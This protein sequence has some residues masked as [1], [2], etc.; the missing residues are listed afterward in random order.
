MHGHATA[1]G[2]EWQSSDEGGLVARRRSRATALV[3]LG[4]LLGAPFVVALL[5]ASPA[6]LAYEYVEP[7]DG[8]TVAEPSRANAAS[9]VGPTGEI[10]QPGLET[11]A[12]EKLRQLDENPTPGDI[13]TAFGDQLQGDDTTTSGTEIESSSAAN[14]AETDTP[15][16][17][18]QNGSYSSTARLLAANTVGTTQDAAKV[19][20]VA[21]DQDD[22]DTDDDDMSTGATAVVQSPGTTAHG[23]DTAL[24]VENLG[25]APSVEAAPSVQRHDAGVIDAQL[26]AV[27][28]HEQKDLVASAPVV[29]GGNAASSLAKLGTVIATPQPR[30]KIRVTFLTKPEAAPDGVRW[31]D[32]DSGYPTEIALGNHIDVYVG[33]RIRIDQIF[34]S[35][36]LENGERYI[37]DGFSVAGTGQYSLSDEDLDGVTDGDKTVMTFI[38]EPGEDIVITSW[39]R[40]LPPIR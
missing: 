9:G 14:A 37:F 10:T 36:T 7:D 6:A 12:A 3:L 30:E 26:A 34:T 16:A 24:T 5:V 40:R 31:R 18:R 33:N 29:N 23:P 39:Y 1:N 13:A 8:A 35:K 28:I 27:R 19:A 22:D 32:I 25:A 17:T 2:A 20:A 38:A 11:L 4:M 21:D 15:D